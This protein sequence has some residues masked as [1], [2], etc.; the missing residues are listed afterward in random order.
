MCDLRHEHAHTSLKSRLNIIR[1][2]ED[3]EVS[4]A[5]PIELDDADLSLA[6]GGQLAAGCGCTGG[7][8]HHCAQILL[9]GA[10][11]SNPNPGAIQVAG[12]IL[13]R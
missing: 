4:S 2:L 3:D 1:A 5:T 12:P 6:T 10:A 7:C 8:S 9:P 11:V 13:G